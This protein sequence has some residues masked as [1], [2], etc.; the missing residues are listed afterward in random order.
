M[1]AQILLAAFPRLLFS[2]QVSLALDHVRCISYG[3]FQYYSSRNVISRTLRSPRD[4]KK[5]RGNC[6]GRELTRKGLRETL[7]GRER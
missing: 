2:P 1:F 6:L 7:A 3:L 4:N 5:G